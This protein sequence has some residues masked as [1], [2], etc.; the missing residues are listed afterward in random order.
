MQKTMSKALFI[1]LRKR[2][3]KKKKKRKLKTDLY[4]ICSFSPPVFTIMKARS[5]LK[6]YCT[7]L[8]FLIPN[9]ST[10]LEK[11]RWSQQSLSELKE[12]SSSCSSSTLLCLH[13]TTDRKARSKAFSDIHV[14]FRIAYHLLQSFHKTENRMSWGIVTW[15]EVWNTQMWNTWVS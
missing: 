4:N 12:K 15:R 14:L 1:L 10:P 3:E 8:F 11:T 6:D 5:A 7:F 2:E 13:S 9:F